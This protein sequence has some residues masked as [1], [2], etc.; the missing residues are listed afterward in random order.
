MLNVLD[1]YDTLATFQQKFQDTSS[2]LAK[3]K[4]KLFEEGNVEKW[5]LEQKVDKNNKT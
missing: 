4:Q 2:T 3:K 5:E 1:N